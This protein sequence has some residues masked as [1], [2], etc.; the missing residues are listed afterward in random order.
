MRASQSVI[1]LIAEFLVDV[2]VVVVIVV[3]VGNS[4]P[5]WPGLLRTKLL[6]EPWQLHFVLEVVSF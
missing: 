6:S 1:A 5:S 4:I 3:V 2:V